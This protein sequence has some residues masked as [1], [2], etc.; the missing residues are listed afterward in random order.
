MPQEETAVQFLRAVS[1]DSAVLN[2][3]MLNPSVDGIHTY[4]LRCQIKDTA[5]IGRDAGTAFKTMCVHYWLFLKVFCSYYFWLG[6]RS[7]L[8]SSTVQ[9]HMNFTNF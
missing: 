2:R 5:K 6:L 4:T 9:L 8:Y 7:T 1:S 3:P